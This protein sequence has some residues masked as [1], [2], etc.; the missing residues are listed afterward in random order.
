MRGEAALAESFELARPGEAA[1]TREA[2]A[3]VAIAAGLYLVGAMLTATALLL[4]HVSW[5]AG[6]AAVAL[7]AVVTAAL[8]LFAAARGWGGLR[9]AF[10]ADLWG[11]VLIAVLCVSGGGTGSPFALI[12]FF[13]IGHAAAFQP[14]GRFLLVCVAGLIAFLLPLLYESPVPAMFGAVACVGIVLALLTSGVVHASLERMREQRRR[15][16]VL[17][18]ATSELNESLDP[19]ETLR[20]IAHMAVPELATL[21]V[22]DVLD[23]NGALSSTL[24]AHADDAAAVEIEKIEGERDRALLAAGYAC[25]A[26]LPMVA[27]GRTHGNIAFWQ[28]GR[29]QGGNWPAARVRGPHSA[30]GDGARQLAS[31]RGARA[32]RA[33]A[34]PQPDAR[35][36]ARD[37]GTRAG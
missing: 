26:V 15:L 5:P 12:Y 20:T 14:R 16:E 22:I 31:V 1:G 28:R 25:A 35:R 4:P 18:S 21:C 3:A 19:G 36:A 32:G 27:R 13:A 11:V 7:D 2:R 29:Q 10:V 23:E 37:P 33:H 24:V 30:R 8:L 17:I 6:I 9:L 34:A